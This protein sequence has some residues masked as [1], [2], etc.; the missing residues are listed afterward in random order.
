MINTD[1]IVMTAPVVKIGGDAVK[2]EES[3]ESEESSKK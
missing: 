1:A 3:S 2:V